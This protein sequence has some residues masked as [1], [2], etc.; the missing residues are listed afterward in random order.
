MYH[1]FNKKTGKMEKVCKAQADH[2]F[3]GNSYCK[4]CFIKIRKD[5]WKKQMAYKKSVDN[6]NKELDNLNDTIQKQKHEEAQTP[7]Y[8]G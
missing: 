4:K 3:M 7:D 2:I 5:F 8:V 6:F 1:S